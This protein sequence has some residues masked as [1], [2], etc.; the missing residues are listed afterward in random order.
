V[1]KCCCTFRG[2]DLGEVDVVLSLL[3]YEIVGDRPPAVAE[4]TAPGQ[5]HAH[6]VPVRQRHVLYGNNDECSQLLNG[7]AMTHQ[8]KKSATNRILTEKKYPTFSESLTEFY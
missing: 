4:R 7:A 8:K 2:E 1:K 3:L 6:V 5:A